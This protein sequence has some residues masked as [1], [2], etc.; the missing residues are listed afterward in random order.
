V[1]L[2]DE[3]N[4]Q[5]GIVEIHEALARA[6][7]SGLDLVEVAP[8]SSPPVCRIMDYGKWKYAQR[9][10]EQR[11]R[12]KRHES[13]LKEIRIRTPKIGEHDL[14]IKLAH[15]REF[16]QRGDHVQFTLRFRGRELAHV[17]E[18]RKIFNRIIEELA[19]LAKVEQHYRR[20]GRRITMKLTPVSRR[21]APAGGPGPGAGG[22]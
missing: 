3:S 19:E 2:I 8:Q 9:K 20:E 13:T 18:G 7:Q 12:A 11:S 14:E 6:R 17:E 10:R 21:Q 22:P 4:Q 16:L 5:V 1:R 15:A